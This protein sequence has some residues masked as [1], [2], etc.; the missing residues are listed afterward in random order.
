[1]SKCRNCG[2]HGLFL[3]VNVRTGLC[4]DCQ[5]EFEARSA[6]PAAPAAPVVSPE[7]SIEIPTVYIGN[8]MK[9]RLTEKYEDVELQKMNVLPDFSKINLCDDVTFSVDGDTVTAKCLVTSLGIV[10]DREIADKIIKSQKEKRPVFSQVLGYD[11]ETG[12][13][14]LVIAFYRIVDFDYT[15]YAQDSDESLEFETVAYY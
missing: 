12:E 8:D 3:M 13:I 14:H 11:D 4:A 1:M 2:R 5:R 15:D 7:R 9:S 6:A 10:A